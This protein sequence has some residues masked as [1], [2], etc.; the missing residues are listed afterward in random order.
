MSNEDLAAKQA[1][2]EE[3]ALL[4][5]SDDERDFQDAGVGII[6]RALADSKA[7]P[8]PTLERQRS[9]FLGPTPKERQ[10]QFEAHTTKQR[11]RTRDSGPKLGRSSTAPEAEL[12]KSF[13]VAKPR[14]GQ[15]ASAQSANRLKRVASLPDMASG[16]QNPFYKQ[17]GTI[18]RELKNGKNVKL[19]DNIKLEPEHKQVLKG[20]IV[21]FYPNDDI[22]M[23]RRMRIHKVIQLG[24]AW[25]TRW[26]DD[27]THIMLDDA[28]Y[29]YSQLLRHLNR[30]GL[31]VSSFCIP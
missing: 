15:V 3:Q 10:A 14:S 8:P 25:V 2:F 7:M 29:T 16:N 26:R 6:D 11:P 19:A 13:P 31:P 4:E 22:S 27:I 24:A 12:T 21:Y 9:S 28:T 17:L 5:L 1:Y 18:P 23:V 20:Q 30:A